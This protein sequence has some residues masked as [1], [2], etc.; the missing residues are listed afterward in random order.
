MQ[1]GGI[2]SRIPDSVIQFTQVILC[3]FINTYVESMVASISVDIGRSK[4]HLWLTDVK[5]AKAIAG[6]LIVS[7]GMHKC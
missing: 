5:L 2:L 1:N 7:S 6:G 3:R 4:V